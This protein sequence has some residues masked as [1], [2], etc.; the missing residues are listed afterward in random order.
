MKRS[1]FTA[2]LFCLLLSPLASAERYRVITEEWAPYNYAE[3]GQLTGMSTEIVRA[4]MALT[5]DEFEIVLQP[6]M[7]TTRTLRTQPRTIMYSLFRTQ[8]RE[9]LYKWVGPIVE[10]SIHPYQLANAP[11]P[12]TSLEQLLRAP[13]ITTRHAGLVPSMLESMGF[14]NLDKSAVESQQLYSM[15]LAGRTEVIV[16]DTDA[17]VAYYSRQLGIAPGMLRPIPIELYRSSLYIAFSRDSDDALVAAWS[18]ALEQLRRS[19]ELA[20]IQQHY[21]RR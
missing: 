11:R 15:L 16:G 1:R 2:A 8:E 21:E 6:S 13:R 18:E 19:G 17:G 14:N 9:P 3:G 20:R 4:I 12:I 7:R 5:G 10:E